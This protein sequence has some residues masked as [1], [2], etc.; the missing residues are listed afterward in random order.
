MNHNTVM[1]ANARAIAILAGY[2]RVDN[3]KMSL[4]SLGGV[5]FGDKLKFYD[6]MKSKGL[7][8]TRKE[9][10]KCG[11]GTQ[12]LFQERTE[13]G[14]TKDGYTW[15]CPVCHSYKTIRDNS[16]F[17]GSNVPLNKWIFLMYLWSMNVGVCTAA[18]QAEVTEKT[19]MDYYQFFRDVCSTRL[20]NDGPTLLGGDGVVVQIDE[21]LFVHKV[22]VCN[23][24]TCC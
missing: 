5:I 21:S 6:W 22:K 9:C 11:N 16:F 4:F 13:Q 3:T 23:N 7:L 2:L 14:G 12:M 17:K 15:R 8:A 1:H 20:L 18:L 24:C 19:A 10:L